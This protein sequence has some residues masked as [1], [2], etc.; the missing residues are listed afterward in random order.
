MFDPYK[1]T[2][3]LPFFIAE[4]GI[5]HNGNI[6]LA[7]KLIDVAVNA[8]CNA[9][10][11]QK[12]DVETVY[13]QEY[14]NSSRQS[15]WG[16]TQREQKEGIE[17]NKKEYDIIAKYC[18]EKGILWSASAWDMESQK[19]LRKYDLPFNKVASAILTHKKLLK[20][21]ASEGR[22]TFISTGMST[23]KEIDEAVDIFRKNNCP[24]TLLHCV[25]TYP[26]KDE[27]CNINMVK[28]LEERYDCPIGYSGHEAGTVPSL[29]AVSLGA[30]AIERHITL[31][32]NM[33]GS[34]Q[35]ASIEKDEI[36]FLVAESR[37]VTNTLGTG[38]KIF[39]NHEVPVA[40]KLR[41]FEGSKAANE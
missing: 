38:Q 26:C 15:P 35:L 8:G 37:K 9:V 36:N 32:K 10:K 16:T 28:S 17:F 4:I 14:L 2:L 12:R 31:D 21:I 23:Y 6:E 34:D 18:K 33:Y 27:D 24:F 19:F 13:T 22:H 41:Y 39:L 29:L 25:S 5:N 1:D 7:K 3:N 40:Q 20:M 30:K 11:F